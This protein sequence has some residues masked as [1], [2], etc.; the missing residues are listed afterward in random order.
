MSISCSSDILKE[1]FPDDV[2][3][4]DLCDCGRHNRRRFPDCSHYKVPKS[5]MPLPETD[6]KST[7]KPVENV[8]KRSS[9][10]PPPTPLK[11]NQPKMEVTTNQ[12][13][14]FRDPKVTERTKA[15]VP[16][17]QYQPPM[18]HMVA[19]SAY[20]DDFVTKPIVHEVRRV[21]PR[22]DRGENPRFDDHTTNKEH[23]KHWVSE[24]AMSFGEL[25]SF[26]GSILFPG[27]EM[28]G[29]TV[30]QESYTGRFAKRPD[31]V[32]L[33]EANI[34]LEGGHS[35]ETTHNDTYRMFKGDHRPQRVVPVVQ[36]GTK[37]SGKF[38]EETQ[39]KFDYPGYKGRQPA[40]PKPAVPPK[41]A[42]DLKFDNRRCFDTEQKTIYRGHDI[43]QHPVVKSCKTDGQD[44]KKPSE[45]FETETSHQRDYKPIDFTDAHV[46]KAVMPPMQMA[47]PDRSFDDRTMSKEFFKDWGVK[48]RVRYGDFH[49]NKPLVQPFDKFEGQ[50]SMQRSYTP[51]KGT[52]VKDFKPE[53]KGIGREGN[54]DFSTVYTDTYQKPKVKPCRAEIYLI[55][56][57]LKRRKQGFELH[58]KLKTTGKLFKSVFG[59]SRNHGLL[60][61]VCENSSETVAC[62]LPEVINIASVNYGRT[63]VMYCPR[64]GQ[65]NDLNCHSGPE[66]DRLVRS[67]CEGNSSCS[68]TSN[69]V[70]MLGDPC[71]NTYKFL[72]ILYSCGNVTMTNATPAP[73]PRTTPVPILK[74][75]IICQNDTGNI[76]CPIGYAV[77]ILR[78]NYGRTSM[79]PCP[80]RGSLQATN[81]RSGRYTSDI[82]RR[83]CNGRGRCTL[84]ASDVAMAANIC[85]MTHKYIDVTYKCVGTAL[86]VG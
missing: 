22:R 9:K 52:P 68:L 2:S 11:S 66:V 61:I 72:E 80:H 41:T 59:V 21:A 32:K 15:F 36:L 38:Q 51:K 44:Y 63:S 1:T 28:V 3:I 18:D 49:E 55:Q 73:V 34:K 19:T 25:P 77:D 27:K 64:S 6:Y 83:R 5:R 37:K 60:S 47:K 65:M 35:M 40:P 81:C 58:T 82:V 53:D 71:S 67:I 39:S 69:N 54:I 70:D 23:Y 14:D 4:S 20:T 7:F 12:K 30:T 13:D 84:T 8:R 62:P 10:R 79:Q 31:A 76:T 50:S 85:P 86:P 33:G 56:R 16:E 75:E 48:P 42:I 29:Q 78:V 45:K 43:M 24:N 57:E 17:H 74:S 46:A 26:A